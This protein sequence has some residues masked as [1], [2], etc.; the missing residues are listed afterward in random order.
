MR[1]LSTARAAAEA[2]GDARGACLCLNW[3]SWL[4]YALGDQ[5]QSIAFSLEFLTAAERVGD[6]AL[7]AQALT[8]AGLCHSVATNYREAADFIERGIKRRGRFTGTAYAY[9]LGTMAMLRGDQGDFERAFD[10][11]QRAVTIADQSG[12]LTLQGPMLT[13]RGMV[14]AWSGAFE[15]CA[16]TGA[17]I[18][19]IA[20]H[21]DGNYLRAMGRSLEGYASYMLSGHR[22][23]IELQREAVT[24]LERHGICLHMSWVLALLAET[25]SSSSQHDEARAV[26][27]AALKRAGEQ[28][29]LGEAHAL[30]VLIRLD[31]VSGDLAAAEHSYRRALEVADL[32]QSPRDRALSDL[33]FGLLLRERGERERGDALVDAA[34]DALLRMGC[35]VNDRL[36]T[37][38]TPLI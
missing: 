25:L 18:H 16:N 10:L 22:S 2:A 20:E 17:A 4:A 9:A 35:D 31:G 33:A 19:D 3:L 15:A 38:Q 1:A 21:I 6:E 26:A 36:R 32:K 27:E 37:N 24:L 11:A 14:E 30:R 5:P 29:R 34:N 28:D 13:Q 12:R 7:V 23:A 8:N